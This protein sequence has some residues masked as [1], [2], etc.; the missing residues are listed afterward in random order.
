MSTKQRDREAERK[1]ERGVFQI[2]NSHE[3]VTHHVAT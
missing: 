3:F 2:V 1:R